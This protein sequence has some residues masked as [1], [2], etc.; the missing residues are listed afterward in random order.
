VT[1]ELAQRWHFPAT[2]VEAFAQ[3][4]EPMAAH[5]FSLQGAVLRMAEVLADAH[6]MET[7]G[8]EALEEAEPELLAHLHIDMDWLETRL[9]EAGDVLEGMTSLVSH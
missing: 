9:T 4:S 3:A 6:D 5:P 1:A 8:R 7:S 2:L